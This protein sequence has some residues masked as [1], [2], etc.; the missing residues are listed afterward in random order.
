M[1][2]AYLIFT[3]IFLIGFIWSGIK[4]ILN[5]LDKDVDPNVLQSQK[6]IYT[7]RLYDGGYSKESKQAE[8]NAMKKKS[9]K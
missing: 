2:I 5:I 6:Q 3:T 7:A 1:E 4:I 9:L 8:W